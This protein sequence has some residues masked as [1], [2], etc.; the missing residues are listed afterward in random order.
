MLPHIALQP[1]HTHNRHTT[2]LD[3]HSEPNRGVRDDRIAIRS[4]IAILRKSRL[5]SGLQEPGAG[6]RDGMVV[7]GVVKRGLRVVQGIWV[8]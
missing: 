2:R 3:R 4:R 6:V 1:E 5:G 8:S 7:G